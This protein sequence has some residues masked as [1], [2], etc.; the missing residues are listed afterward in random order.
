MPSDA[1]IHAA[2]MCQIAV[3]V[4]SMAAYLPQ[5]LKLFRTKASTSISV[6]SWSAWSVSSAF[7]LFY[8]I[9][10][11][12]QNGSGWPLVI[13]TFFGLTFVLFTLVLVV[14]FRGGRGAGGPLS[15]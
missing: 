7:A 8:A 11:L 5:W 6:R 15:G 13:S 10:K 2:N 12:L 14:L 9:V 4:I 3:S 1:V